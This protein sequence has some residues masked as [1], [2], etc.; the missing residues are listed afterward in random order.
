MV[1]YICPLKIKRKT[2]EERVPHGNMWRHMNVCI[3][4]SLS[5]VGWNETKQKRRAEFEWLN[6][7]RKNGGRQENVLRCLFVSRLARSFILLVPLRLYG[8]CAVWCA[9]KHKIYGQSISTLT[10]IKL[11]WCWWWWRWWCYDDNPPALLCHAI[12]IYR[13]RKFSGRLASI[14]AA[15]FSCMQILEI[16]KCVWWTLD[17]HR[18]HSW[19]WRRPTDTRKMQ[20]NRMFRGEQIFTA[21]FYCCR[22]DDDFV[23]RRKLTLTSDDCSEQLD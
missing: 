23:C 8:V 9:I 10:I 4:R 3:V 19:W 11:L 17:T 16:L 18:H 5:L 21:N 20:W 2:G 15:N 14:S 12:N 13:N 7:E 1:V 6:K 22:T